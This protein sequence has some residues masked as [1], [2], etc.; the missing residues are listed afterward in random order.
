MSP[1][2]R[3]LILAL[4]LAFAQVGCESS[5]PQAGDRA[6]HAV[7]PRDAIPSHTEG[8][9]AEELQRGS[10]LFRA[11]C[12]RCHQFYDPEA[13]DDQEWGS[14]MSKMSRKAKLKPEQEELLVRYLACFRTSGR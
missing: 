6:A 7:L 1:I 4:V 9:S 3:D 14:W 10:V 2:R 8:C 13:Y 11:K 5:A 12:L